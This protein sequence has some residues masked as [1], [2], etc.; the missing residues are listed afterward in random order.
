MSKTPPL[1]TPFGFFINPEWIEFIQD[2]VL[3]TCVKANNTV[4]LKGAN[5]K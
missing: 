5:I 4:D 3:S 1:T 2:K